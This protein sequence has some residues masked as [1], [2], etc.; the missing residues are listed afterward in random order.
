MGEAAVTQAAKL[1]RLEP[2]ESPTA[3]CRIHG[4]TEHVDPSAPLSVYGADAP[5]LQELIRTQP[6]LGERL[7]DR[8]PYLK[9]QI[10][11]GARNEMARTVEDALARRTRALFLD[12]QA[13][14]EAA[15][16]VAELLAIELGHDAI[17]QQEQ[18]RLYSAVAKG[19]LL[20]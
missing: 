6:A 18:V 20:A 12:A 13:S 16:V 2:R 10:I 3:D 17:W 19:Y 7:H 4:W 14:I 1:G 11:W 9:A 8:L 15:P 5:P